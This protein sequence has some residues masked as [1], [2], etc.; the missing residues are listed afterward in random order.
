MPSDIEIRTDKIAA[1]VGKAREAAAPSLAA[2]TKKSKEFDTANKVAWEC[3]DLVKETREAIKKAKDPKAKADLETR[4]KNAEAQFKKFVEARKRI[5]D[6]FTQ[7]GS[8]AAKILASTQVLADEIDKIAKA[9]PR[10]ACD[11]DPR[12]VAATLKTASTEL[13]SLRGKLQ[14]GADEAAGQPKAP[15][16]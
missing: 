9:L 2:C 5:S 6:E 8:A 4:L 11:G 3:A 10:A 7:A 15:T 13:A 16:I 1:L 14:K 12:V